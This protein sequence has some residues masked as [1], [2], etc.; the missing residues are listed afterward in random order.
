MYDSMHLSGPRPPES[1][2]LVATRPIS[3]YVPLPGRAVSA[4]P[5]GRLSGTTTDSTLSTFFSP[6]LY[7]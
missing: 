2:D 4:V 6:F 3:Q 1:S 7:C 5:L